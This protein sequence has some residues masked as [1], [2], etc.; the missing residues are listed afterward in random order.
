MNDNS[1]MSK[2]FGGKSSVPKEKDTWLLL[3]K[4]SEVGNITVGLYQ[5]VH[6]G[7]QKIMTIVNDELDRDIG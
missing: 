4:V 7:E 6:T 1:W 2:F 3:S 5:N